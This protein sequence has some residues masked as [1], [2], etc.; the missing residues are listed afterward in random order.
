MSQQSK[1][2]L[3]V[4]HVAEMYNNFRAQPGV[5]GP[6]P[7][8]QPNPFGNALVGGG[9]GLIRGGLGAYG[10]KNLGS[11][12][13]YVQS[14]ITRYFSD[15]QYYFQVNDHYVRNKLKVVL[16]PFLHGGHWTMI[17][18]HVGGRL[19]YKPP[20]Y[21]I[22]ASDTFHSWCLVPMLFLL[23]SCWVSMKSK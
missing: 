1:N 13:E 9:S 21:D 3:M 4:C 7:N 18:E 12:A 2:G 15:P 23:A 6:P 14:T 22:N 11:I 5:S 10:E 8:P 19:S 16:L 20:I 17:T